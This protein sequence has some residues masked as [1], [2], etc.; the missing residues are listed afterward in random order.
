[1][2][3]T[4]LTSAIALGLLGS[5]HCIGMCGPLVLAFPAS[6]G[7]FSAHLYYH[8]GRVLTYTL[9]GILVSGAGMLLVRVSTAVGGDD[10]TILAHFQVLFAFIAG[11]F[12]LIFGLTQLGII[13]EPSW[14]SVAAPAKIPGAQR[15]LQNSSGHHDPMR[16]FLT[17][18]LMGF[19]PCGLSFAAL[20]RALALDHPLDGG[21]LLLAFGLSTL[22]GLM[23]LGGSASLFARRYW[24]QFNI[25]AGLL[26]IAMSV[27]LLTD[28]FSALAA[29][30]M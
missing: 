23:L 17:G 28:V 15:F 10:L 13:A 21:L 18:M 11:V 9:L 12:L 1:M 6:A 5:G 14:M 22:P 19:L 7:R 27:S 8:A 24:R 16:L 20:A 25:L 4:T 3:L 26:M 2:E 29:Q 30:I